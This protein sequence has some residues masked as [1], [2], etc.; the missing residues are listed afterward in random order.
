MVSR[1]SGE[2]PQSIDS[3]RLLPVRIS[4]GLVATTKLPRGERATKAVL[5]TVSASNGA[6]STRVIRVG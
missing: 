4:L 1:K 3:I 6:K 5:E 2:I